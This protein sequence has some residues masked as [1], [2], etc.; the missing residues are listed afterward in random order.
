MAQAKVLNYIAMS[1]GFSRRSHYHIRAK[2]NSPE[3]RK[4]VGQT[5]RHS[6][7]ESWQSIPRIGPHVACGPAMTAV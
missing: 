7:V 1:L 5:S 2:K 3:S 4:T 6:A